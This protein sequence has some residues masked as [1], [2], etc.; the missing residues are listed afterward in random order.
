MMQNKWQR[1]VNVESAPTKHLLPTSPNDGVHVHPHA[2]LDEQ[3]TIHDIFGRS[4]KR[5]ISA[6]PTSDEG[7]SVSLFVS[8]FSFIFF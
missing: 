3:Q 8:F 1:Q 7:V 4:T 6:P 2:S 5:P